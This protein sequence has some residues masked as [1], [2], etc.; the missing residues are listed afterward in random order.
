MNTKS[1]SVA[2]ILNCSL[3]FLSTFFLFQPRRPYSTLFPYTT[4]FRSYGPNVTN[5]DVESFY[6]KKQSPD[7]EKPLSFGL[8]SRSEEHTLNS[9]HV[10]ISYA[11]FCLK[12][13]I[14]VTH[15]EDLNTCA[16]MNMARG[17]HA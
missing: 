12:K 9:S 15:F 10:R 17:F 5:K 2:E 13:K 14:V 4:L 7:P 8:N 16:L 3:P 11:V 6:A 1:M